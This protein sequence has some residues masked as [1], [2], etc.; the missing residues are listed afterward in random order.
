VGRQPAIEHGVPSQART[1]RITRI[2]R[3]LCAT[4]NPV[5]VIDAE[6]E[7][8]RGILGVIDGGSPQGVEDDDGVAC[9]KDFLG[10]IEARRNA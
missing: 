5:E 3:S 8:G 10:R 2:Y 9:R 1:L 7:Q 6:T 4:A